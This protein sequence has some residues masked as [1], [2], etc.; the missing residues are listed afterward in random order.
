MMTV[1]KIKYSNNNKTIKSIAI[2]IIRRIRIQIMITVSQ[3]SKNQNRIN[4][5]KNL[6]CLANL[7]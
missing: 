3:N 7:L 6:F 1:T 2:I 5:A 4:R